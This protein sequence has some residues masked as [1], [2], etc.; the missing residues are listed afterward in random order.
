MPLE[1]E[2][3]SARGRQLAV[4]KCHPDFVGG[5]KEE[6][7]VSRRKMER[8]EGYETIEIGCRQSVLC[9]IR[10]DWLDIKSVR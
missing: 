4:N 2:G 7:L 5:L 8:I 6:C 3:G 10:L 1:R 9:R